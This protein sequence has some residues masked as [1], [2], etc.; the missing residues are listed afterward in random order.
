MLIPASSNKKIGLFSL[1]RQDI[2]SLYGIRF[3]KVYKNPHP[4]GWGYTD[5]ARLRG[6][7]RK[8][9]FYNRI[10]YYTSLS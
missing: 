3:L 4:E 6:L 9:T 1:S 5:E 10:W 2:Y 7:K 8:S